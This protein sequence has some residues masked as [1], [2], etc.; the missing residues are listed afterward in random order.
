MIKMR[1]KIKICAAALMPTILLAALAI[2]VLQTR[3]EENQFLNRV[4]GLEIVDNGAPDDAEG[5]QVVNG[6]IVLTRDVAKKG[7]KPAPD[8]AGDSVLELTDGS[9]LHG[10]L[11]GFGKSELVWQRADTPAPLTFTPQDVK[12]ITFGASEA[13][14][15]QKANAT[16][17]LVG[18][19]WLTGELTALQDGKFSL[20]IEGAGNF[21]IDRSKVEWLHLSKGTPPDAYE[22]PTGPMGLA[23][24]DTGG[25]AGSAW[26]YADGALIARAAMPLTRR[27]EALSDR[28][29]LEFSASDGGSAVRGLT[30]WLHP[31][32]QS[33]GYSKGSVYLRFQANNISANA[34]D[35]SNMKNLSANMPEEKNAPKETRYR[36]LHDRRGGKLVIF[37][38]GKKVADWDTA[39]QSEPANGGSLSWQPTYWSSNMSWTLSKVRVRPWD[40]SLEPDAKGDEAAKDLISNQLQAINPP[41]L[42]GR[43][44]V[45]GETV[46]PAMKPEPRLLRQAGTLEAITADSVNF[47]GKE[48]PRKDPLFIRLNRAAAGDPPAGSIARIWLA[49][50]GEFDVTALGFR[51]GQLKVRTSFAGDITLPINAVRAIEFPHRLAAA[52]KAIAE[53]GDTLI[54]RNGDELRGSLVSASLDQKVNWKPVKGSQPAEFPVNKLAGVLLGKRAKAADKDKEKAPT[55][56]VRFRNGDWLPGELLHLDKQ[57]LHLRSPIADNLQIDRTGI[58]AIYFGQNSEV[59]V[60]DGASDP[61]SWMKTANIEMYGGRRPAKDDGTKRNPWRYLDGA[62]NLPRSTNRNGYGNGPN[63]GRSFDNLPDKVEV[64]FDISTPK[65]Q[66]GYSIQLFHDERQQGLM[67]QGGWDSAYIYDMSP[68]KNGG[69]FLNQSQQIEFAE[70]VGSEGNRRTFRFLADRRTGKLVMLVN[71][72][73]VGGFG[74]KGGAG[75]ESPK[76][77]KGIAI[78]PQPMNSSVTISNVWVGPWSGDAPDV[79]KGSARKNRGGANAMPQGGIILNGGVLQLN[80]VQGGIVVNGKA[81]FPAAGK[82]EDAADKPAPADDK[83]DAP[84]KKPATLATDLIALV[85]GDETSGT[86]EG[87]SATELHLQCD[88]GRLD[89]PMSRALVAEFAGPLQPP[90]AG[91][92]LHL[93]GKGSVTV[94]SVQVADGRVTCHS[95]AAGNLTFSTTALSEIVFQPRNASPPEN[96]ADKQTGQNNGNL[97]GGTIILNNGAGG[98]RIQGNVIINGIGNGAIELKAVPVPAPADPG[99]PAPPA[100][101]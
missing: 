58:R 75:K 86:L 24:W 46:D 73:P 100:G 30:L 20:A 50:R 38:N 51:D 31:G 6:R 37:V 84:E 80:G 77:G 8:P 15:P 10:K 90:A 7:A 29:D 96:S 93:A 41:K 48:M 66:A 32:L 35:G 60:W 59:P 9:Q 99:V 55:S 76:P 85:N 81:L 87:A 72:I 27:F 89:I 53:G 12:R 2:P 52:D 79:P 54:F 22:G 23:G 74:L 34:F 67:I 11:T 63:I 25:Q 36:I 19:D 88:V 47:S 91:V 44:N 57:Q 42:T 16:V 21:E 97:N 69:V 5:V 14:V 28:L 43:P 39:P 101:K 82:K 70:S 18:S 1:N 45:N 95:A 56:A 98:I 3:A 17:K 78:I 68:R 62:F 33:Q 26:D 92:R 13:A 64:S 61:Q 71:G 4:D 65:A 83:K 94:D 40:G 49:Q